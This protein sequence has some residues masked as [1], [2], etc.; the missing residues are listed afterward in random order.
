LNPRHLFY[1]PS[2]ACVKT[3]QTLSRKTER[4]GG[5]RAANL[6]VDDGFGRFTRTVAFLPEPRRTSAP[7]DYIHTER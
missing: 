3:P 6:F 2:R 5:T 4:S 1:L 7:I